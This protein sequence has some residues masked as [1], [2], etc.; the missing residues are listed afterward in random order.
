MHLTDVLSSKHIKMPIEANDRDSS[1]REIIETMNH[2]IPDIDA[3]FNAVLERERIMTT[4]VGNEIAIPH[5]KYADIDKFIIGMG[6]SQDGID[7]NSIDN[8]KV[9]LI[10]L[11]IGP[12]D[13]PQIHIKLLSRISRIMNNAD[14]REKLTNSSTVD[15]VLEAIKEEEKNFS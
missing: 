10:F 3:A 11:L 9:K 7:F 5:C 13:D 12:E 4:G 6:I 1:I 2:S 14:F 15:E 8:K